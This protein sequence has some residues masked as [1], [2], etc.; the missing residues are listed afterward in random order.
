MRFVHK[1]GSAASAYSVDGKR[2]KTQNKMFF[3]LMNPE[4]CEDIDPVIGSSGLLIDQLTRL[5]DKHP[6]FSHHTIRYG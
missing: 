1:A 3:T 6:A 4:A 5:S 2:Q